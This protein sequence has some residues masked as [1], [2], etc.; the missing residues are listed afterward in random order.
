MRLVITSLI[1]SVTPLDGPLPAVVAVRLQVA[2][3]I[4]VEVPN[5]F[6]ESIATS[7]T[8]AVA[9]QPDLDY[10]VPRCTLVLHWLSPDSAYVYTEIQ[11]GGITGRAAVAIRESTG[12]KV[13]PS[14]WRLQGS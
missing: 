8:R 1:W 14:G 5:E 2:I 9:W 4:D 11:T 13:C 3:H 10:R 12:W 7:T 6:L